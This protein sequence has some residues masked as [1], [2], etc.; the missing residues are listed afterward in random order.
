MRTVRID[1]SKWRCGPADNL[2]GHSLKRGQTDTELSCETGKCCL[3]FAAN[4]LHGISFESMNAE[5]A[6]DPSCLTDIP[7]SSVLIEMRGE[8]NP[9][10][11]YKAC[12]TL[13]KKAMVINDKRGSTRAQKEIALTKL[14]A[15][16]D[17]K[18][19]FYG[20]YTY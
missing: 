13:S 3:G 16:Y 15:K 19:E 9:S 14:F 2:R 8:N 20:E 10:G 4:Q 18:L 11:P 12:S 17:I 6:T 1:R 7:K 5:A